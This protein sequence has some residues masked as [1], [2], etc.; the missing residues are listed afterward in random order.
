H[1]DRPGGGERRYDDAAEAA[2]E[3]AAEEVGAADDPVD[4][5]VVAADAREE[6]ERPEQEREAG[7]GGVDDQ[8]R[9]VDRDVVAD[10]DTRV[11]VAGDEVGGQR[12]EDDADA[13][14]GDD[15]E[16]D[17]A[18]APGRRSV[19]RYGERDHGGFLSVSGTID[20]ETITE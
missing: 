18:P 4:L 14:D 6:L 8:E 1:R 19:G 15:A 12:V 13:E 11:D 7:G 10:L 17:A 9:Q 5:G 20:T 16:G 2:G 3:D